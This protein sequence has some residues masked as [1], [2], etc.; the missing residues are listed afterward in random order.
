MLEFASKTRF[1]ASTRLG[2][3]ASRGS[4]LVVACLLAALATPPAPAATNAGPPGA[5]APTAPHAQRPDSSTTASARSGTGNSDGP[6]VRPLYLDQSGIVR[7]RD[8]NSEVALYGAN[9]CIMSGSDYRM[10]GLV[11]GDRKEMVDEGA[12]VPSH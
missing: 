10:A 1:A 2:L 11:S 12:I 9:Y 5:S 6:A 3:A 4:A 7:W 8:S